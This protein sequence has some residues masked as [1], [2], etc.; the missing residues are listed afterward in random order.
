MELEKYR[1]GKKGIRPSVRGSTVP[2]AFTGGKKGTRP[3]V[4]GST[5]PGAFT[6]GTMRFLFEQGKRY[7]L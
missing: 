7:L 1:P 3:S 4:R 5:V 6:G 2:G